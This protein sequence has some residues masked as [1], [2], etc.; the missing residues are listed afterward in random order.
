MYSCS[1]NKIEI[2]TFDKVIISHLLK[3]IKRKFVNKE[4]TI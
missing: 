4:N 3:I 2:M 1:N